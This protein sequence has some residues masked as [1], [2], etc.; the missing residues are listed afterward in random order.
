MVNNKNAER[1]L[2]EAL[3]AYY[4]ET[5][6]LSIQVGE[7]VTATPARE[8]ARYQAERQQAAV[9]AITSDPNVQALCETFNAQ[10]KPDSITPLD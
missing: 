7:P 9:T 6:Q 1:S 8:Q 4:G 5:P 3:A 10:V 2:Q